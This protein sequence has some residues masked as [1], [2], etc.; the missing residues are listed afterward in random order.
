MLENKNYKLWEGN[1]NDSV[2]ISL[3]LEIHII[4]L[5]FYKESFLLMSF[6]ILANAA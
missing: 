3:D 6:G 1:I 4:L 5:H 2:P